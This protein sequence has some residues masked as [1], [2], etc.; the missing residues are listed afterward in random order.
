MIVPDGTIMK[1]TVKRRVRRQ[2]IEIR[3][4]SDVVIVRT[5]YRDRWHRRD[6]LTL[7]GWVAWCERHKAVRQ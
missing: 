4:L 2:V 7:R 3:Q 6:K 1:S 5:Q